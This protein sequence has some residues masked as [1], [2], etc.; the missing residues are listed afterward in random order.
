MRA[1]II[2]RSLNHLRVILYRFVPFLLGEKRISAVP[3]RIFILWVEL[4][5]PRQILDR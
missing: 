5:R 4:H 3:L 1:N 2:V